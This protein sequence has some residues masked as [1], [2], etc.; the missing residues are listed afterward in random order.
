[1]SRGHRRHIP[2]LVLARENFLFLDFVSFYGPV[3]TTAALGC[4][5]HY[6]LARLGSSTVHVSGQY[7]SVQAMVV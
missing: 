3:K 5:V 4:V 7:G 2:T 1:M 6:R